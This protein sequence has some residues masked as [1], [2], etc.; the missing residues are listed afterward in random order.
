MKNRIYYII[1]LLTGL[2][3]LQGA[4]AQE[5]TIKKEV[6]VVKAYEPRLSDAYKINMLPVMDDTLKLSTETTYTIYPKDFQPEYEFT[7][8]KPARMESEYISKL[9][10]SYLKLA[11]GSNLTPYGELSISNLRS[12]TLSIGAWVRHISSYGNVK[13][14]NDQK[15]FSGYGDTDFLLHGKKVFKKAVLSA[16]AGV[17]QDWVHAYGYNPEVDT[18]LLRDDI[19]RDYLDLYG[20]L[21]IES[22]YLDSNHLNYKF[23]GNYHYFKDRFKNTQNE[24]YFNGRLNKIFLK[25]KMFGL[26]FG[27]LYLGSNLDSLPEP[28]TYINFKPWYSQS[29]ELWRLDLALNVNLENESGK[30]VLHIYPNA[31]FHFNVVPQYL[32]AFVG[33][34][35]EFESHTYRQMIAENPYQVP[36]LNVK[37]TDSKMNF[38]GGFNGS[39]SRK[40]AYHI[41]VSY[42]LVD[43]MYFFVNDTLSGI[44]NQFYFEYDDVEIFRVFGE[45]STKIGSSA[46]IF[47][48]A[49]YYHYGMSTQARAWNKPD[50]DA[51]ATFRYNMRKKIMFDLDVY[52]IGKRYAKS[53][54]FARPEIGL[55]GFV[56]LNFKAEYQFTKLLSFYLRLNNILGQGY[57]IWNQYP[58][59]RFSVFAGFSYIL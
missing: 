45:V 3:I 52:Y 25:N 11:F 7:P 49:N 46:E 57:Q 16:E 15:V 42:S 29:T 2:F 43:Q 34:K 56:D 8:L 51:T 31:R 4:Y 17:N 10:H 53:Y 41:R 22:T 6:R 44:G 19:R 28:V 32:T 48:K 13:L 27:G 40:S 39:F 9:Y 54:E 47:L 36:G 35:G 58:V 55:D 24:F 18:S 30:M 59:Q 33:V 37:G 5:E 21:K 20:G 50:F 1:L 23:Q 14:Q 12:K 26:D 38:F